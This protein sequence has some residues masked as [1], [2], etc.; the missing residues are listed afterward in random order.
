MYQDK[1]FSTN[2]KTK[3]LVESL[4]GFKEKLVRCTVWED[5]CVI[6]VEFSEDEYY[7]R[8]FTQS[9][10]FLFYFFTDVGQFGSSYVVSVLPEIQLRTGDP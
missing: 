5:F 2:Y 4:S 6:C 7:K 10:T 1:Y 8:Q 9:P 3:S